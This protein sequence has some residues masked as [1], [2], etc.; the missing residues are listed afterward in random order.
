MEQTRDHHQPG[1]YLWLESE[2]L[3]S[4]PRGAQG[5]A[6]GQDRKARELALLCYGQELVGRAF[7]FFI[8]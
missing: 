8:P 1:D 5:F 6:H 3:P 7:R 4:W 2:P